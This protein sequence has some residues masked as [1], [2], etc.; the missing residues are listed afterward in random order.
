VKNNGEACFADWQKKRGLPQAPAAEKCINNLKYKY[1]N[2][3]YT[4]DIPMEY[5]KQALIN[6]NLIDNNVAVS[7][8]DLCELSERLTIITNI[9]LDSKSIDIEE[10]HTLQAII[11][12]YS[13]LI[14]F[15]RELI[16]LKSV[17]K[18]R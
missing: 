13:K 15:K 4:K 12:D 3:I 10:K 18:N 2:N 1:M 5:F 16:V 6:S 17:E 7:L 11:D 9:I 14:R 8:I